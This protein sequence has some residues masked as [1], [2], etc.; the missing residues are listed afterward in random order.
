MV[1]TSHNLLIH[2]PV[3]SNTRQR[4]RRGVSR[5]TTEK[6]VMQ[7]FCSKVNHNNANKNRLFKK[8]YTSNL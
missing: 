6:K 4:Y 1:L 5:R 2:V 7:I 8:K 3:L